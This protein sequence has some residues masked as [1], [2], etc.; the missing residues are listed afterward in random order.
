MNIN[1]VVDIIYVY[2]Y[3]K[4]VTVRRRV[5]II[6]EVLYVAEKMEG[7]DMTLSPPDLPCGMYVH[8]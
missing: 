5:D 7:G 8:A 6:Q 2:L 1:T 4:C 3:M